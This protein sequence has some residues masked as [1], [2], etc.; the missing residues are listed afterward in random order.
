MAYASKFFR[1]GPSSQQNQ[2][3]VMTANEIQRN[4]RQ[5]LRQQKNANAAAQQEARKLEIKEW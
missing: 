2:Q 4:R 5:Q 1:L 3:E